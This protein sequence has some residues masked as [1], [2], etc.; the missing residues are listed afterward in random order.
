M[1]LRVPH[2]SDVFVLSDGW[3]GMNLD[4]V[5]IFQRL[6]NLFLIRPSLRASSSLPHRRVFDSGLWR[7]GRGGRFAGAFSRAAHGARCR[8][9]DG[10]GVEFLR[11]SLFVALVA[12]RLLLVAINLADLRRHPAWMLALAMVHHP[13]L[14]AFG[15]ASG[16]GC[17]AIFAVRRRMPFRATAD[18]LAAPLAL[19]MAFEQM[20]ALLAGAGYGT[21]TAVRW[22]VTYN[23]LWPRSGAAR[24]WAFRCIRCRPTRRWLSCAR[25][26]SSGLAACRAA[27][28]RS[29]GMG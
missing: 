22:A 3:V 19:A 12:Q 14:A 11:V 26:F 4:A 8:A 20:G 29:G 5:L 18:A 28:G 15:A 17:A 21:G 27:G 23:S 9:E 1:K 10:A 16:A 2:P 6:T 7:V 24:R 13:L 25:G